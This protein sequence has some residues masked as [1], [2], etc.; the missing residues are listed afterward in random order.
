MSLD[1]RPMT[2]SQFTKRMQRFHHTG[3]LGPAAPGA[4][5]QRDHRNLSLPQ[6]P[7]AH[8][9]YLGIRSIASYGHILIRDILDDGVRWQTVLRETDSPFLQIGADLF[10][11]QTVEPMSLEQARKILPTGAFTS[12]TRQHGVE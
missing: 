9:L 5:C 7:Q 4:C 6:R 1:E 11:L 3:A 8:L 12:S 2:A 10:V